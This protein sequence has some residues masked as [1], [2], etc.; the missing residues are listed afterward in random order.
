MHPFFYYLL[1]SKVTSFPGYVC[2]NNLHE[3]MIENKSNNFGLKRKIG[4]TSATILVI[5]N[6]IGIGIF[7][8][9]GFVMEE[10]HDPL[11]MLLC[12]FLGGLFALCGALCYGELGAML[13]K[14]GGEYVFLRE[15]LGNLMGFLS[16]WISL[17]V[18]FSA[19]IAA[20]SIAFATFFYRAIPANVIN[21]PFMPLLNFGILCLSPITV[22][23][24]TVIIIFTLV[25]CYSLNFGCSVQNVLT[26]F[27]LLVMFA[28]ISAGCIIGTGSTD[29]FKSVG[30][31][32]IVFSE[33]FAVSL[34][35]VSFAYS[36]WNASAYVGS[37][38]RNPSQ[39]IPLSLILGTFF[40]LG[41][42]LLMNTMFIYALPANEMYGVLEVG[43]ASAEALFGNQIGMFFSAAIGL[44]L[45]SVISVMI[46][47]G[48]R[49]YYAMA[50]DGVFFKCFSRVTQKQRTP[51]C[52]ICLQAIIAM[53]M[54]LTAS[55]EK[56]LLYVG[57]TLSVFTTLTVVGLL[58]L[59]VRKPLSE[60]PY[61]TLGYLPPFLFIAGNLWV[62]F[63][64]IKGTLFTTLYGLVTIL[65]GVLFYLYFIFKN[66]NNGKIRS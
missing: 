32:G 41:L 24:C 57:F 35:L 11:A 46:M 61:K 49:V 2:Q 13:P 9:S 65:A 7:T 15:S 18:G 44:C 51:V 19:P 37:E 55:Y 38:I 28:F 12:W 25:H 16:G 20:A 26:V 59:R 66:K 10:L 21:D 64:C 30:I 22:L 42:Y 60:R 6:M 40:V 52:S 63:F 27:K 14:A 33:R 3:N 47:I 45:L 50:K 1:C 62:I 48:P 5:A 34:I 58:L 31:L 43:S 29:N 4:L 23:A 54:A 36:G 53:C 39:N 17:F 56:L 8:T